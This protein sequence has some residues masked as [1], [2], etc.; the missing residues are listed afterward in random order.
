VSQGTC[1]AI[2]PDGEILTAY[3]V[4]QDANAIEVRFS[5]GD[6][7]KARVE[8]FS[9]SND[10]ALLR[11][12]LR[13]EKYLSLV[14][15]HSLTVGQEVFTI[16]FPAMEILGQEPKFTDGVVSSL[17]G[18]GGEDALMQITVPVQPG[19]SGGPLVTM[20]GEV[21]GVVTATA[22]VGSFLKSTGT[23]PQNVNWAISSEY[24]R[25]LL[26][27]VHNIEQTLSREEAIARAKSSLCMV[28]ATHQ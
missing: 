24:A 4:I 28:T 14:A 13:T 9:A 16:G 8:R 20:R 15:A 26:G 11:V 21:A 10:L 17:T 27:E 25:P 2:G 7:L 23:L 6:A 18:P 12:P 1:F 3:H 19:N 5:T 22:A